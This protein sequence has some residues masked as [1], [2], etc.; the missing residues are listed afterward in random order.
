MT[1]PIFEESDRATIQA[2][3]EGGM[4]RTKIAGKWETSRKELCLFMGW[5]YKCRQPGFKSPRK[6]STARIRGEQLLK[7]KM[8]AGM[9]HQVL[10][11]EGHKVALSTVAR[12]HLALF[13]RINRRVPKADYPV[14]ESLVKTNP[15]IR[16]L[17]LSQ[18]YHEATGNRLDR[19][20]AGHWCR[21]VAA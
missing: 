15:G 7:Q 3:A 2:L 14:L 12:W 11:K 6:K 1:D 19:R 5:E 9:V 17:A 10:T 4:S 16:G 18:K 13:G 20:A 21:K 8:P